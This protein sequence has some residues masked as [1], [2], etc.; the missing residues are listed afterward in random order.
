[1]AKA[2][3]KTA[4]FGRAF[5]WILS[6]VLL[7]ALAA[8][9][10]SEDWRSHLMGSIVGSRSEVESQA[11]QQSADTHTAGADHYPQLALADE[12]LAAIGITA[13]SIV[14]VHVGDYESKNTFPGV[15]VARPGQSNVTIPAPV[16]GVVRRI[17]RERGEAVRPGEPLFDIELNH[18]ELIAD[19]ADFL[20]TCVKL[21][22]VEKDLARLG[23]VGEDIVPKM[24]RER[25]YERD[26]LKAAY[27][28]QKKVLLLHGLT[29][30]QI[31]VT[32]E[33]NKELVQLFRVEAPHVFGDSMER[34]P[35]T[36][37]PLQLLDINV[38]TGQQANRGDSL[39]LV[40]SH[41][42]LQIEGQAFEQDVELLREAWDRGKEVQAIFQTHH[43]EAVVR[44]GLTI[45]YV[46]NRIDDESRTLRFY[47]RLPNDV[48]SQR[49]AFERRFVEWRFK[50]GQR[51]QLAVPGETLRS[52]IVLPPDAVADDGTAGY[53]FVRI[54]GRD[55]NGKKAWE[56]RP[57]QVVHRDRRAV[58]VK[59]DGRL[60]AGFDEIAETGAGQL[61]V[62]LNAG[63]GKLQSTCPCGDH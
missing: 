58:V 54:P 7:A 17:Y 16:T 4:D 9:V 27:D 8:V 20:T 63:S 46:E 1:M 49:E 57:V 37:R 12:S 25:G 14:K 13:P 2:M 48:V 44:P 35:E 51:C 5:A 36:T 47:L 42:E 60:L 26:Q 22:I 23:G 38:E 45:L 31:A 3:S 56:R 24:A 59:N 50:P 41:D 39:C 10:A 61:L 55:E 18:E 62:A 28:V 15:V 43:G 40:A 34:S 19:Q 32:I 53:V 6:T 33:S 29:E 30:E 52:V 21:E 11:S